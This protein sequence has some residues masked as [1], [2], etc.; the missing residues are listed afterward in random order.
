MLII[1]TH[2]QAH[3]WLQQHLVQHHWQ[4]PFPTRL[5][6]PFQS[7]P[8]GIGMSMEQLLQ[9]LPNVVS[10]MYV[11]TTPGSDSGE[12]IQKLPVSLIEHVLREVPVLPMIPA[13]LAQGR[14]FMQNLQASM[15]SVYTHQLCCPLAAQHWR[16]LLPTSAPKQAPA[17]RMQC[18]SP[19]TPSQQDWSP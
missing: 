9:Q 7:L 19:T 12:H 4:A 16:I 10:I 14:L 6:C 5:P 15:S 11:F 2:W 13:K 1:H 3:V 18:R 17:G 8:V